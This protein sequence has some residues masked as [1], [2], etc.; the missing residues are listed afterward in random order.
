MHAI[1]ECLVIKLKLFKLNKLFELMEKECI[2]INSL[3]NFNEK[4]FEQVLHYIISKKGSLD[5]VGKTVLYK[6]L[7]F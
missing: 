3:N 2:I 4:K 7:Y 5:N 6:M 1:T